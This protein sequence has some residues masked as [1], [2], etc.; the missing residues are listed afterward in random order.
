MERSPFREDEAWAAKPAG[1][2]WA[3]WRPGVDGVVELATVRG[4][5]VALPT[6]FHA[7]DQVT[8]VVSGRRRFLMGSKAVTLAAGQGA[9]IPAGAAHRSFSEPA[10]VACLNAYLPAGEY[11][12][13]AMLCDLE[14]L[15]REAGQLRPEQLAAV[16]RRHRRD[17]AGGTSAG[18]ALFRAGCRESVGRAAAR[19]GISREGFS[20]M[21]AR[22]YGMP[23]H[24]YWLTARLNQARGLLRAG[25]DIAAV[26]AETGFADQ[27]HLGRRFRRAFGV[28]PG[29]YRSGWL[30]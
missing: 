20:R 3:Y 17:V 19:A 26:A 23:P 13:A 4:R 29:S 22:R 27:S 11:A 10:G 24:A 30:P 9:L 6:H 1:A 8:F 18:V 15:W 12:V 25:E 7:E 14:R 16:A 21:F 28:T 2:G 5:E